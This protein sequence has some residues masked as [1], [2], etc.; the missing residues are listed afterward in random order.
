M[1]DGVEINSIFSH[2]TIPIG[3]SCAGAGKLDFYII[4]LLILDFKKEK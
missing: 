1:F 4:Y 3:T 2:D